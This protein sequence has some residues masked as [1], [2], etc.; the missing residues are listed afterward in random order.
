VT[1]IASQLS[2]SAWDHAANPARRVGHSVEHHAVIGSTNDRARA[3][4]AEPDG[5]GHAVVAE[6]QTSGRGRRGRAWLS[7]PGQNLMMSVALLPDLPAERAGWLGIS[8]ALAVRRACALAAPTAGIAVRWPNDIVDGEGRKLAGLLI[9][10]GVAGDRLTEAV[11]GIGINANWRVSAMPAE[12]A[13][14]A[15]S[16]ADLV[17]HDV[18]RVELLANLLDA[19][20]DEVSALEAERAPVGR[21]REAFWLAGRPVIVE[22]EAG[23]TEG[24]VS[25]VNDDG[26]LLLTTGSGPIALTIGEVVSVLDGELAR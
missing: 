21:L 5:A 26:A 20:D 3:L 6:L 22:A 24:V 14:R 8:V 18:D 19:L 10:T 16:L 7:P 4:L 25:G 23:R 12:I 15:T 9:E 13:R 2:E 11:I 1:H 17:G